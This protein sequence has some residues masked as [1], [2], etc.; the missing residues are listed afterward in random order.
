M[1]Y[2]VRDNREQRELRFDVYYGNTPISKGFYEGA[3]ADEFAAKLNQPLVE[4][5][6][7]IAVLKQE[8]LF[9]AELDTLVAKWHACHAAKPNNLP[10]MN[11]IATIEENILNMCLSARKGK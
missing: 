6:A 10:A 2:T 7:E 3:R 9:L 1:K 5:Q 11:E 8:L 4:L